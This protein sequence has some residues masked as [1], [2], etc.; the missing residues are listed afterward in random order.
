MVDPVPKIRA[1][2][3][4]IVNVRQRE[5]AD[6]N[7]RADEHFTKP[8]TPDGLKKYRKGHVNEPGKIQ[9]HWGLADDPAHFEK[10]FSYGKKTYDSDKVDTVIKAQNLAGL[11]D[12]FND[13]NE[14]QY[15]SHKREP[16]GL[17][18]S[19]KYNWPEH[20]PNGKI[21]FGVPTRGLEN[22]K[23]ILYPMGGAHIAD[24]PVTHAMY[25]ATHGNYAPGEQKKRNYEWKTDPAEHKFGYGEKK[26]LN[27][28]AQALHSERLDEAFPK[29]VIV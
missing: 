19:R 7:I 1:A 11:A 9:K 5:N 8:P 4:E 12:Q 23:E 22:A 10:A 21:E 3:Y 24:D 15:A 26:I 2:G 20:V 18:F 14:G 13:I 29:T 6:F 25:R 27:G 17:G 28:A 16:L